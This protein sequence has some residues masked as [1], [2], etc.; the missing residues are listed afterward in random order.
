MANAF[1]NIC[2]KYDSHLLQL[3]SKHKDFYLNRMDKCPVFTLQPA[4]VL[5]ETCY[6]TIFLPFFFLETY[7]TFY[8]LVTCR[9]GR[10]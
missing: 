6:L 3:L 1:K 7:L 9:R 4:T 5:A 2:W 10:E 8:D